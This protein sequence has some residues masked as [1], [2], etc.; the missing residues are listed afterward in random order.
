MQPPAGTRLGDVSDALVTACAGIANT[1]TIDGPGPH[2][3]T[4]QDAVEIGIG[5][6]TANNQHAAGLGV[7]Y[8][9]TL[10][11]PCRVWSWAGD[12]DLGARRD[13]AIELLE[14]VRDILAADVTLDGACDEAWIGPSWTGIPINDDQ[15]VSYQIG[16]SIQVKSSI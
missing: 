1:Q 15:G 3:L 10:N 5:P 16:F 4:G 6:T 8:L 2:T 9:E 11:I 7:A 13:R 12:D 14:A